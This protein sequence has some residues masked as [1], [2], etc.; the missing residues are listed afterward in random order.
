MTNFTGWIHVTGVLVVSLAMSRSTVWA[1]SAAGQIYRRRGVA[2]TNW[3][4]DTWT[5]VCGQAT[6]LTVGQCDTVWIVDNAGH[7]KQLI[8]VEIGGEP[9]VEARAGDEEDGWTMLH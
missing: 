6:C 4:G 3:V 5:R 8:I 7:V 2:E 9:D 1:L